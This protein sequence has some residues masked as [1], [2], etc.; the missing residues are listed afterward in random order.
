MKLL[1]ISLMLALL[2]ALPVINSG[3]VASQAQSN[4]WQRY[5]ARGFLVMLPS[6]PTSMEIA[7][8]NNFGE[9]PRTGWLFSSYEDKV[10]YVVLVCDKRRD[11]LSRFIKEVDQ[12]PIRASAQNFDHD[13]SGEGFSGKQYS[14][15]VNPD[16]KGV[17]RFYVTKDKVYV[18]E[19]LG[20]NIDTASVKLFFDSFAVG[21][22]DQAL[23]VPELNQQPTDSAANAGSKADASKIFTGKE[24]T[25]K[26]R[27]IMKPEPMYTDEAR[28]RQAVGTV[29]LRAVL[30]STG[31]VV[32]I[33]EISGLPHGLS[34]QA[35]TAARSLRFIP[36]TKD[37]QPVHMF[38]QLEYNFNLY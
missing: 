11:S 30:S 22:D 29:V 9:R 3:A 5:S 23:K 8:P 18:V 7:L 6:A 27:I 34:G 10:V 38:I 14:F 15:T 25:T 13:L 24:V 20:E 33:R 35:I 19:A 31:Q 26:P 12:Y 36:A 1:K 32:Q 28:Q 2:S 4:A 21:D 37:G 16:L 17:V